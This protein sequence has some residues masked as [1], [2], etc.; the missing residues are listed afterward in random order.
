VA[1]V[2]EREIVESLPGH[3]RADQ[4]AERDRHAEVDDD[5]GFGADVIG[6]AGDELL[7]GQRHQSGARL[8]R[9]AHLG[10]IR[11]GREPDQHEGQLIALR[12]H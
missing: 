10:R 8:Q 3:Q 2:V 4:K 1:Q 11:A 12:R 9:G 5:A 6:G 7:V